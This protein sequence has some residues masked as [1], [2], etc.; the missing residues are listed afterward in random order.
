MKE[1][2]ES[3]IEYTKSWSITETEWYWNIE[4]TRK[5]S[6]VADKEITWEE[7][8]VAIREEIL[9]DLVYNDGIGLLNQMENDLCYCEVENE[10]F[11][12]ASEELERKVRTLIKDFKVQRIDENGKVWYLK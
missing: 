8:E 3:I 1:L 12:K 9:Y 5:P 6:R 11:Q 7:F 4:C 10:L 2:V